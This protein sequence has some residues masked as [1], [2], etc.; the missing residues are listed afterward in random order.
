MCYQTQADTQV[1]CWATSAHLCLVYPHIWCH[2]GKEPRCWGGGADITI[3]G[4]AQH[5]RLSANPYKLM[6][7]WWWEEAIQAAYSAHFHLYYLTW[8]DTRS[9]GGL[10]S[11]ACS[12]CGREGGGGAERRSDFRGL[13]RGWTGGGADTRGMSRKFFGVRVLSEQ[14]IFW[15]P[16]IMVSS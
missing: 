12:G 11:G 9:C 13:L 14:V 4:R 6:P 8:S 15:Q 5:A 1:A 10:L 16:N 3:K 2:G 7:I